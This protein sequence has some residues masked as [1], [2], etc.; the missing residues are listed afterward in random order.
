[1]PIGTA[2]AVEGGKI[3]I[4]L[5]WELIPANWADKF[6]VGFD[7]QQSWSSVGIL[8]IAADDENGVVYAKKLAVKFNK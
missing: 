5:M 3:E 8:P 4:Q 7:I 1:M 6:S 2:Q